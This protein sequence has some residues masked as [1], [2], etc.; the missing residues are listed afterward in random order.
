MVAFHVASELYVEIN[1]LGIDLLY[2]ARVD[3]E[4]HLLQKKKANPN[5]FL[6]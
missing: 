3:V 5:L 1:D 4:K 6:I 2:V